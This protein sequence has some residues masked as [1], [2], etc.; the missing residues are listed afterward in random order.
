MEVPLVIEIPPERQPT[1]TKRV[2][3]R[4]TGEA[5]EPLTAGAML[6]EGDPHG[7][8][9]AAAAVAL[10]IRDPADAHRWGT[11]GSEEI[12]GIA[13]ALD[14]GTAGAFAIG[15]VRPFAET[16]GRTARVW[17][18]GELRE[19]GELLGDYAETVHGAQRRLSEAGDEL[20][21]GTF[22]LAVATAHVAVGP[23][24]RV[25]VEID[26]LGRLQA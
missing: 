21:P 1:G 9:R 15:A 20:V 26:G 6:A 8:D 23:D 2:G 19:A 25:A 17:V 11:R 5:L 10:W 14:L 4:V 12:G 13:T 22:L 24:D 16:G 3:W 18:D 7:A